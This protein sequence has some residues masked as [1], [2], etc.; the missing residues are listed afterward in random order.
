MARDV[1]KNTTIYFF[2]P[3]SREYMGSGSSGDSDNYTLSDNAVTFTPPDSSEG[4]YI[5]MNDAKT[6]WELKK[7]H[8]TSIHDNGFVETKMDFVQPVVELEGKTIID[9]QPSEE[10]EEAR[11][12][13]SEWEDKPIPEALFQAVWDVDKWINGISGPELAAAID[14]E[15]YSLVQNWC[16]EQTKCEEYYINLGIEDKTDV[17]YLAYKNQKDT[18][19]TA[20]KQRKVEEGVA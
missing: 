12:N 7:L 2:D 13:G 11:W 10:Y 6:E 4:Y 18:I 19:V 17:E 15:T 8:V 9:S 1:E 3:Y 16:R 20:Q 5:K 14:Q